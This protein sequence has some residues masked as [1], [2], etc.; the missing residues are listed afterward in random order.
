[1]KNERTEPVETGRE[2]ATMEEKIIFRLCRNKS[3]KAI[4]ISIN[5]NRFGRERA[6]GK[7]IE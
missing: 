3:G 6:N 5:K 4:I 1:M 2:N 7:E